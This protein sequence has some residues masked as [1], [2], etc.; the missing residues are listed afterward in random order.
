MKA[1]RLHAP[2]TRDA[3][4]RNAFAICVGHVAKIAILIALGLAGCQSP[5]GGRSETKAIEFTSVR[6]RLELTARLR[7]QQQKSKVGAGETKSKEKLFEENVKIE[8]E[9]SVYHPN[10]LEFSLAG[11]F[12]LLQEDFEQEFGGR[13]RS[14][15]DDGTVLEF[16]FEGQFLKKKPYPGTVYAR[17]YRSLEA[18]PFLS[19]LQTTTTNY[20]FVWQYVD[21]KTPTSL[22]FNSTDVRLE[23]LDKTE[24]PS[25]QENTSLRFDTSYRFSDNNVLS[26]NY[27]RRTVKE[28]PFNL[29]YDSDELTLGHHWDFG[30]RHQHRLDSKLNYFKQVGTFNIERARWRETLRLTHSDTLRSWY[31]FE[32]LD[33]KQGS[34]SGV[35]PIKE[36]SYYASGTLEHRLYESLVSQL[37][38]FAQYQE[39]A[40]GLR[41]TRLGLQPSFDY[42]KKNPWGALLGNYSF[43]VQSEDRSGAS[44]DSDVV[45]ERGTFNDPEPIMLNNT[46]VQ[47][48][49]I[50]ITSEDRVTNYRV[51]DDYRVRVVGDRVEIE[52]VPTGRILDG[53]TVLIDYVWTLGGDFKLDTLMHNF[54][55]RQN[56]DFGLSPYYRHRRQDQSLTPGDA[57]GVQPEDIRANIYGTEYQK[58]PVRLV[59]EW[60]GH[61]SNVN[62]FDAL[63]LSLDLTHHL[64]NAGTARLRTR[65]VDID[66]GEPQNRRTR[67]LTVEGRYRQRISE[68]LI[69]EGAALYRKE[70]D[71]LSG[72]DRGVDVDLSLEWVIRDTELR[73]T[74]EYGR[75]EDE[76]SENRNQTLFVQFRRRF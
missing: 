3:R 21:A 9:G 56:F 76:F 54:G 22:Q 60:E 75:F 63:R 50:F 71:S 29:Q 55:L 30:D 46:N 38:A 13:R 10:F 4:G 69:V 70:N 34:L 18:R 44:L 52:R 37:F 45:D 5:Q 73:V 14:S 58:G 49:S 41:I 6:R 62:P 16:D 59:A 20:G 28:S 39:F 36:T 17:R 53:Q 23:P 57:M 12:G 67:L 42:R 24:K 61:K 35:P 68:Y 74:Y 33:R 15:G 32:I 72:R 40:Q 19:S 31:Q 2:E 65:W 27:D 7:D 43:R 48:S 66:R 47:I 11:L 1:A 64:K 26:F 25:R 51:G 8:T